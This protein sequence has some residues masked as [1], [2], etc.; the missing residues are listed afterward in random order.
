M[1]QAVLAFSLAI[2]IITSVVVIT[3]YLPMS[4]EGISRQESLQYN[5]FIC[6]MLPLV[7]IYCSQNRILT[8]IMSKWVLSKK[9]SCCKNYDTCTQK[10]LYF[11]GTKSF[12]SSICNGLIGTNQQL[13]NLQS[14]TSGVAAQ[15]QSCFDPS[16]VIGPVCGQN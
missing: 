16:H 11:K 7:V 5:T 15:V 3:S 12:S 4:D 13:K 1:T 10:G 9:R 8:T 14:L 6:I 2:S